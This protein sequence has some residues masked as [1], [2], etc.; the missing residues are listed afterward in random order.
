MYRYEDIK[1]VHLE[2]T[3]RCQA[4][5]PMCDRNEN[6][7]PDNRHITNAELSLE[8][9]KRIFTPEFISQLDVM[10][11]CGNLGDPI[12]ARD[13]LEVFRY[14]REHNPRMWLSMNTNAGAKDET[15]WRELAQVIGRMGAVIF[16]VD[17]LSDTNHLYR[18]NVVWANVER[19]MRAFID[20]GGRARW[21]F[22]IFGHNE[23]QVDEAE[24]L[25]ESW[26][27]EKFMRKKSGRFFTAKSTQK[28]KHQAQNRKGEETA[29]IAKP[30]RE[31]NINL[32]LLKQKEIEKTY[33][34]MQDYYNTC[35]IKCKAVEKK[36]IFVTAEGL[37]MPCCWTGG[38]MYKWW[39]KDPRV[40]QIW[41]HIDAAG[42]KESISLVDNTLEEVMSGPLLASITNSWQKDSVANG[43]LGVC[44]MKCG[45]EFD[46]YAE[47]FK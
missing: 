26:G 47:Q 45:S 23:H 38:R 40:E 4:A 22:I 42:G 36:E 21:D 41:D 13:T 44:A 10:Y 6:G 11:M 43:K 8:D 28:D 2:I 16:S 14:F 5:C 34:S 17:G 46:P 35:T 27:V 15:W 3:Q 9:C 20:A 7:G 24:A 39:H 25:A 37:L 31:E 18:Q 32:A 1:A 33:G 19:N 29:V 12:V 30:K